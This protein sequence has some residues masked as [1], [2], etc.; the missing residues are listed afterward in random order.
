MH[1]SGE[2]IVKNKSSHLI[3]TSIKLIGSKLASLFLVA[4]LVAA[5]PVIAETPDGT[6]PAN[7]GVCDGLK[8]NA[9]PGLYGL[10][11]AYCE[12]QDLDIVGDKETPNN[13]ILANYNKK[14][15]AGDPDMPCLKVPCPC[16]TEADLARITTSGGALSCGQTATTAIIRNTSPI[17]FASVDTSILNCRFTDTSVSPVVSVRF[18]GIDPVA[19]QT[20]Y[21]QIIDACASLSP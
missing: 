20:C 18:N 3:H 1:R 2:K 12:A 8:M 14:K 16:W 7:E 19:A 15:Q 11:V 13:K 4:G 17:Q 6:T 10:C 9:T 5:A 21:T